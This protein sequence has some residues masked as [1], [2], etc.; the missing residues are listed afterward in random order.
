[1]HKGRKRER[2][3]E[4]RYEIGKWEASE[5]QKNHYFCAQVWFDIIIFLFYVALK[6]PTTT[7]NNCCVCGQNVHWY[8]V[9]FTIK[10][11]I[12]YYPTTP[13][14]PA[15]H[16]IWNV[17]FHTN[18][19]SH[20][21]RTFILSN[22]KRNQRCSRFD[23]DFCSLT[24]IWSHSESCVDEWNYNLLVFPCLDFCMD[25][26]LFSQNCQYM[27]SKCKSIFFC[28]AGIEMVYVRMWFCI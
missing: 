17:F 8:F 2:E 14:L 11:S 4:R 20:G 21:K 7:K 16:L 26:F 6:T 9:F 15:A 28:K 18:Q 12:S 10:N 22:A 25:F 13:H 1:M 23:G 24:C 5:R 3:T 19:T 27:H